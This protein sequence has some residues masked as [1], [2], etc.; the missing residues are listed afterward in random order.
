MQ[1]ETK[2]IF[3]IL[4]GI[5]V[6]G[7]IGYLHSKINA[8]EGMIDVAVDDLSSKTEITI[9]EDVL[10][11]AIQKAVDREVGYISSRITRDLN[12]EIRQQVKSTI[13]TTSSD[14]KDSVSK[15]VERQVRNIDISDMQ[16]EVVNRAKDAVAEK[17]DKK[18]DGLLDD[19]NENL[20]NVQKIY[21]SIAKS[22]SRDVM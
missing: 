17:F 7:Y 21:S 16:R 18:L 13:H 20:N 3:G 4:A 14:I 11:A 5:G 12:T 8:I 9:N 1:R 10:D 6:G 15:E 2:I 19:F 22:M